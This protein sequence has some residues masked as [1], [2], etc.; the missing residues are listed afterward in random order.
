MDQD[1]AEFQKILDLKDGHEIWNWSNAAWV[2]IKPADAYTLQF[3]SDD[4]LTGLAEI[5]AVSGILS[6]MFG[7]S[8]VNILQ[9]ILKSMLKL[10]NT[11]SKK[12]AEIKEAN[13]EE[14]EK[15]VHTTKTTKSDFSQ[16]DSSQTDTVSAVSQSE[17][18]TVLPSTDGTN[19][20]DLSEASTSVTTP[21]Q[22]QTGEPEA[23]ALSLKSSVSQMSETT[24][25]TPVKSKTLVTTRRE[26]QSYDIIGGVLII[27]YAMLTSMSVTYI[28]L[29]INAWNQDPVFTS[30]KK[31]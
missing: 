5:G 25:V 14:T 13:V 17:T 28:W 9:L 10:I 2:D 19:S 23:S 4:P 22:Q 20:E 30:S 11:V 1:P 3:V 24:A 18:V 31:M 27:F 21:S 8:F 6:T 12:Q 29:E 7:F 15:S 16:A 26:N